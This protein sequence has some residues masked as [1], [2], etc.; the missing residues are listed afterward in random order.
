MEIILNNMLELGFL[1]LLTSTLLGFCVGL[2]KEWTISGFK[3]CT[4][5]LNE[6][7]LFIACVMIPFMGSGCVFLTGTFLFELIVG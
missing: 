2:R 1:F 3:N 7:C 5:S 6:R 4:D